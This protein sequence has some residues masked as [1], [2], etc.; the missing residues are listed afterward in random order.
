MT[1]DFKKLDGDFDLLV[2]GGGIYGAWTAYDAARRGL[3]VAVVDKGDWASGTSSASSKLLHGGLRYLEQFHFAMVRKSLDE[4]RR[5]AM[6]APHQVK[7]LRFLVPVYRDS[8]VGRFRMNAGLWLYD[9]LAGRHQPVARHESLGV[10][11]V[12]E[13]YG[14]LEEAN[15]TGG[16]TYGDC[17]IDDARFV[18]EIVAG[19]VAEGAVAVNYAAVDDLI[20]RDGRICG[21]RLTDAV[22]GDTVEVSAATVL[23]AAGPWVTGITHGNGRVR[24]SKGV[25]LVMP[26]LDTNDA[27]LIMSRRDRRVIFIIPWYGRTL[28]GT[29]DS[30]FTGNP[31]NVTVDAAD[32]AYLLEQANQVLKGAPWTPGSVIGRFA[33]V[34]ALQ[35][36]ADGSPE[37]LS[38]EWA[39]ESPRPGL[40]VSTGGKYTSARADAGTIVD[41]MVHSRNGHHGH[42]TAVAGT[43]WRPRGDFDRWRV[44]R[45]GRA[46][47]AGMDEMCAQHC[48]SYGAHVDDLIDMVTGD[49]GLGSRLHPDVPFIKAEIAWNARHTMPRTL[50]DLLRRRIPLVI[51]TRPDREVA[52][53]AASLAGDVLGWSEER[54]KNEVNDVMVAWSG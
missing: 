35:Y 1:R 50:T 3:R 22:S 16:L 2:V 21:A 10:V 7:P 23:N 44:E 25:H 17:Q 28:L 31:D 27:M 47:R 12:R 39:L 52:R 46:V 14:F 34:R 43:P 5:L 54:R 40:F 30:D 15:L 33:G 36:E 4:R 29:T 48:L 49:S 13:R 41:R 42:P 20:E 24:L 37:S 32:V 38:R 19:A 9:L 11:A 6:L 8:R 53:V 51:L 26:T 18:V 45:L